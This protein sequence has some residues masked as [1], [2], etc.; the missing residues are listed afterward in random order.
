MLE[1]ILNMLVK[2]GEAPLKPQPKINILISFG[3]QMAE[4]S[5]QKCLDEMDGSV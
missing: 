2:I 4:V 5:T 1:K 3:L